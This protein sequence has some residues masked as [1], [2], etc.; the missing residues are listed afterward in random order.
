MK[1]QETELNGLYLINIEPHVDSRGF[2]SRT[3]CKREFEYHGLVGD[4]VQQNLS[5]N[6]AKYTWRGLHRQKDPH[7]EVKLIRCIKGSLL[8][9]VVDVRPN[10]TT[11]CKWYGVKLTELNHTALYV[12]K[13]FLHGFLTLEDSTKALYDV[14]AF[15][16][17]N[18][19][20]GFRYDDAAFQIQLPAEPVVI[21][22]KDKNWPDFI[23]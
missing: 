16:N 18:S 8:D 3:I 21:S 12:P 15:Y 17:P 4:F 14:S 6:F 7:A 19:E 10:S 2:F 23:P 13:G 11:Y 22:N 9:V 5:V 20:E 1:F